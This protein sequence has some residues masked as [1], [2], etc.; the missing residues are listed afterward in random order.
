MSSESCRSSR[1]GNEHQQE[2]WF[3]GFL[4]REDINSRLLTEDGQ[5]L[6]RV[7]EPQPGMGLKT[8]LSSRWNGKNHHFVVIE[9]H[10]KVLIEG[11]EFLSV[12]EMVNYY[13]REQKPIT[14]ST[15]ALLITPIPKQQWELRHESI[16]LGQF[17]AEGAFGGVYAGVLTVGSRKYQVK[18]FEVAVKVSK[19]Q[20]VTKRIITEICK[21][22]RILRRYRHPNVVKFYGVAAEREPVM[23]VMELVNG[24]ALDAYL[25]KKKAEITVADRVRF[26]FGAAKGLE[27]LHNND[28]IHRDVA[29]RNCLVHNGEV[30]IS[31]F[32]LSRE[33]SNR[34][35]KYK[36]KD[37]N[38][39]LPV[40]WLAPEVLSSAT[41]SRKS[42]VFSY[43]I[44]LWEIFSDAAL[45]YA[46][47]TLIEVITKVQAGYRLSAPDIMPKFVR[48]IMMDQCFPTLPDDRSTMT[49][50]RQVIEEEMEPR[51]SS[52]R[53]DE[54]K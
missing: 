43:G 8:V 35:K 33:L 21:E 20:K 49:Q 47:M 32:G 41:Y 34:A 45:P 9:Q 42:D 36:I 5:F 48:K 18:V 19:S 22:A 4:S 23:L 46:D 14:Q 53:H 30:K 50:I 17:L 29:A 7:T 11:M 1:D 6:V 13:L 10:G 24:G 16:S 52:S 27:Y 38:Q 25:Q 2:Q 28:C 3:H 26:A 15:G 54:K 39:R 12:L 44:L 40:R 31:D 51:P 37:Q